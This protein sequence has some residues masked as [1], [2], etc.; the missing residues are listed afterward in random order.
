MKK[1]ITRSEYDEQVAVFRWAEL[2][3]KEYPEL[4][5]LFGSLNGVR[6]SIGSA[7]K[8]KK[9]G[10]KRGYPDICLDVPRKPYHGLRIELKKIGGRMSDGQIIILPA[11]MMQSYCVTVCYGADEAISCIK[12]Y[13]DRPKGVEWY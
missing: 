4:R 10:L 6:L 13:L 2:A 9:A 11:L 8:A 7:V 5:L 12:E 3:Q 1:S